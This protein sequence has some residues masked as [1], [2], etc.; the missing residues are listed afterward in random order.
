MGPWPL[1][2]RGPQAQSISFVYWILFACAVVVLAIV[3]GALIYSGIKFRE[4]PGHVAKQFHG[5]NLLELIWTVIPTVMVISFTGLSWDRLNFINDVNG[6]AMTIK[7][8]G[9]QW[10]WTYTYPDQPIF[11]LQDGSTL[12]AG[13]QL[14]IPV[15]QKIKLELT[16][17]DVIH[18]FWVPNIGGKKDAVPGHTTTMWIQADRAGTYKGQCFEFCGDGHADMLV[19]VVAHP[20]NEYAIWAKTAVD[21]ANRL[22][23]PKTKVGKD[24]FVNGPCAGCHTVAG[25]PA[26]GK[27]GPELTHIASKPNIAGVLSPVNEENLRKWVRNAPAIKPGVV[28]PKFEGVLP[29][30]QIDAIV[31]WLLTL[32]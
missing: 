32:K 23:D 3:L 9:K 8:E 19:T 26:K 30:D 16:A 27:V 10:Q 17:K 13:E 15:G 7:V 11:K 18:S 31:Q 12:I 14:D 2:P 1:D 4:R 24:A 20:Q 22:N 29:D 5:Q 6:A 28:M 21:D 25:T